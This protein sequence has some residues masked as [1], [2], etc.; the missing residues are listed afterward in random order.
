[1]R[2][3]GP[4]AAEHDIYPGITHRRRVE[5]MSAGCWT[6]TDEFLGSGE[7]TFEVYFHFREDADL[8]FEIDAPLLV[9]TELLEGWASH[10]YGSRVRCSTLCAAMTGAAPLI[11]R[12]SVHL[13]QAREEDALCAQFAGS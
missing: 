12:T 13:P 2:I 7:H 5:Q 11:V 10:R 8:A 1:C 6:V 3:L 4:A 9:T